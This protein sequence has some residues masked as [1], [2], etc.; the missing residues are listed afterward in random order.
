[1]FARLD[2]KILAL[3]RQSTARG[4]QKAKGSQRPM[5]H[6]GWSVAGCLQD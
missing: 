5:A 1:M 4:M 2:R 3:G 6:P